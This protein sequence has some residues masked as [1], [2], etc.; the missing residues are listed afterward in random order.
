MSKKAAKNTKK[1]AKKPAKQCIT[2]VQ[3]NVVLTRYIYKLSALSKPGG[4]TT[5]TVT[6]T[7]NTVTITTKTVTK[8]FKLPTKQCGAPM[9]IKRP[10]KTKA[11]V[12]AS[13]M[14]LPA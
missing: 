6:Q 3:K 11:P 10:I 14:P 12:Q 2:K 5:K 1:S 8:F 7:H 4:P 13:N 9:K